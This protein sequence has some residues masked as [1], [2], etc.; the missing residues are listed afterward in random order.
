MVRGSGGAY[1]TWDVYRDI[2]RGNERDEG[3]GK[4]MTYQRMKYR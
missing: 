4:C 1:I 3:T 2:K